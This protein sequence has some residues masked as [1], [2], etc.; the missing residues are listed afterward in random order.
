M[1]KSPFPLGSQA[2]SENG[3]KSWREHPHDHEYMSE[4]GKKGGK[5]ST[6]ARRQR[7][8]ERQE[9]TRQYIEHW[10]RAYFEELERGGQKRG[11]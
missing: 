3:Q 10:Q 2:C 8:A 5:A 7:L 4:L 1:A 11:T 6:D 9:E